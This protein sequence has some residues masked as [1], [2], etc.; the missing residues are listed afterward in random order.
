M[1]NVIKKIGN[2]IKMAR[3]AMN[4]TQFNLAD[5]SDTDPSYIGKVERGEVN[6]QVVTLYRIAK[7]LNCQP[8][9]LLP[10]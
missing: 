5:A 8:C 1:N 2:K 6:I 3:V 4:M 10:K 9:E 7:A